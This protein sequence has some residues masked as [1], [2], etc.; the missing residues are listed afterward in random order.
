MLCNDC[1][2]RDVEEE[3]REEDEREVQDPPAELPRL[4][5][6]ERGRD[7]Q[8]EGLEEQLANPRSPALLGVI[9]EVDIDLPQPPISTGVR[10]N[11]VKTPVLSHTF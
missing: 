9:V 3:D 6:R 7:E 10:R 11:E 5:L 4:V 2:S 1:P 8:A